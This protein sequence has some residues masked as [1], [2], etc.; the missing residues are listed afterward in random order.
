MKHES[1]ENNHEE[2][3]MDK[4]N[5][6]AMRTEALNE[7]VLHLEREA[8]AL[9][10]DPRAWWEP[11]CSDISKLTREEARRSMVPIKAGDEFIYK[12]LADCVWADLTQLHSFKKRRVQAHLA[13]KE[14]IEALMLRMQD[15][16]AK[17]HH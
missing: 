4:S 8:Q 11:P 6:Q 9:D 5:L 15:G 17:N 3:A 12:P 2:D 1:G 14:A 10:A 7:T 16:P 13:V